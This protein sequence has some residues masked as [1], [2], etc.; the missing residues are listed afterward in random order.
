M[1]SDWDLSEGRLILSGRWRGA[2]AHRHPAVQITASP[3]RIIEVCD[4][5]GSWHRSH[6]LI[7]GSGVEHAF[8]SDAES[9]LLSIYLAPHTPQGAALNALCLRKG[10]GGVWLNPPMAGAAYAPGGLVWDKG[11]AANADMLVNHLLGVNADAGEGPAPAHRQVVRAVQ[12][13]ASSIPEPVSLTSLA[14]SLGVSRDH[15]GRLFKEQFGVS[16]SLTARWL[17]LLNG[18]TLLAAGHSI[19]DAAHMAGFA[20][21]AHANRTCWEM[22][23]A[24]PSVFARELAPSARPSA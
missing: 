11:L 22:T 12:L 19:T 1:G 9:R 13:L 2:A 3:G 6:L 24:P 7:I 20:D 18:M 16:F 4:G 17:R 21:G 10:S 23:G 5:R 15:L 14:S 8:I